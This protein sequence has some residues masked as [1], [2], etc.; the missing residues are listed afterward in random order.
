MQRPVQDLIPSPSVVR[1][2]LSRNLHENRL[3]RALL[4]V[5]VKAAEV[6]A[7]LAARNAPTAV[8]GPGTP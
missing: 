8:K 7:A 1:E 6:E 4:R 2:A 3:L 5:S